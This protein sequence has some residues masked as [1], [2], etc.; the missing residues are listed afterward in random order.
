M[1]DVI[2]NQTI[3]ADTNKKSITIKETTAPEGYEGYDKEI[4]LEIATKQSGDK[5]I[6]DKENTKLVGSEDSKVS[7]DVD[8]K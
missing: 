5:Y 8:D 7:L 4:E 1:V 6:L 3:T 2:K